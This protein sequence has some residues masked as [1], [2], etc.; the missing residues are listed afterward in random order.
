[1]HTYIDRNSTV[2]LSNHTTVQVIELQVK[3]YIYQYIYILCM[4]LKIYQV[5]LYR[6]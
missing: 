1:M 4:Y 2:Y 5:Q 3:R 6:T